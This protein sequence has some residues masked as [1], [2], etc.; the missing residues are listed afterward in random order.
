MG[1]QVQQPR[2]RHGW[3]L[4]V[5]SDPGHRREFAAELRFSSAAMGLAAGA[6]QGGD[7]RLG[8]ELADAMEKLAKVLD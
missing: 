8:V 5:L 4:A 2:A 1:E 6:S 7:R 3:L